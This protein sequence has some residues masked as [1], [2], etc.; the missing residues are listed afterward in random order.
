MC[1]HQSLMSSWQGSCHWLF[2][3]LWIAPGRCPGPGFR[4]KNAVLH[5]SGLLTITVFPRLCHR[6]LFPSVRANL[7]L[8]ENLTLSLD[9]WFLRKSVITKQE[10]FVEVN[11]VQAQNALPVATPP[12]AVRRTKENQEWKTVYLLIWLRLVQTG[13]VYLWPVVL[14]KLVS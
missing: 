13:Q 7:L 11:Q 4:R 9:T 8:S 2:S 5:L 1:K 6:V 10:V 12:E 14:T 3:I